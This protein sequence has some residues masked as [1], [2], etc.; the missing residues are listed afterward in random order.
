MNVNI[1]VNK[2]NPLDKEY[3]P[4][5]LV[6][7]DENENN[8]HKYVN[9]LDKPMI[10]III[11][12]SF[13]SMKKDFENVFPKSLLI[14]DSGYRSYEYQE[15]IWED[16][17]KKIGYE[18]TLKKVALPGTSEHQTGYAIDIA[19]I[20]DGIYTDDINDEDV[21]VKWLLNN[22]YKY[23]FILRYPLGKENITGYSYEP[24]HYRFVDLKIAKEIYENKITL[25]EYQKNIALERHN[26]I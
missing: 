4:N 15:K 7:M 17:I 25:E 19:F 14:V 22:S 3:K 8:F 9:P 21:K 2:D 20:N 24:W 1:L 13:L 5:D 11:L 12:T 10:S 16:N 23:G 18:N 6:M 26:H